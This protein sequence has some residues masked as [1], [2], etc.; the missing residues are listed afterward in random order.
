MNKSG[1]IEHDRPQ[2]DNED[3]KVE[4]QN[5]LRE[6]L[7]TIISVSAFLLGMSAIAT[8]VDEDM[9]TKV[10]A[11]SME[12]VIRIG[13]WGFAIT[14]IA[15]LTSVTIYMGLLYN[16]TRRTTWLYRFSC[17]VMALVALTFMCGTV[18][19]AAFFFKLTDYR[20]R[21][22]DIC[23]L[24]KNIDS[25]LRRYTMCGV[26]GAD[27]Y[28]TA[29]EVCNPENN[30]TNFKSYGFKSTLLCEELN[31]SSKYSDNEDVFHHTFV[32]NT[33][34]T[35]YKYLR[36]PAYFDL[37]EEA[38]AAYCHKAVAWKNRYQ[39]CGPPWS[40]GT[41]GLA[42]RQLCAVALQA[43]HTADDC[44]AAKKADVESCYNHCSG[45][46][47]AG[48]SIPEEMKSRPELVISGETDSLH[49]TYLEWY[50]VFLVGL[51]IVVPLIVI[52]VGRCAQGRNRMCIEC[53][54][55]CKDFFGCG[56]GDEEGGEN[57]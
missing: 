41:A 45:Q 30:Y 43:A 38:T 21:G 27:L 13:R 25:P 3:G 8:D 47:F 28:Q 1:E 17:M 31:A 34:K 56:K 19:L 16:Q 33:P 32:W 55:W 54:T 23:P 40:D 44:Q 37:V 24:S 29:V 42:Q 9:D 18:L 6:G 48:S 39:S 50:M 26:T 57:A 46:F 52:I 4:N 36:A 10:M 20:A 11:T 35:T 12:Q 7:T 14:G 51:G 49:K 5:R 15:L 22:P 53:W 2:M